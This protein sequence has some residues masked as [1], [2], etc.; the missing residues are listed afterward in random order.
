MNKLLLASLTLALSATAYATVSEV[1]HVSIFNHGQKVIQLETGAKANFVQLDE[2]TIP[3]NLTVKG[4]TNTDFSG[5]MTLFTSGTHQV[6]NI[7]SLS[8]SKAETAPSEVSFDVTVLG[9]HCYTFYYANKDNQ[10][11]KMG[12]ECGGNDVTLLTEIPEGFSSKEDNI[13]M[14]FFVKEGSMES[15]ALSFSTKV[16]DGKFVIDQPS[17]SVT[18]SVIAFKDSDAHLHFGTK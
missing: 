17:L 14:M 9:P 18:P 13:K 10:K 2:M 3:E 1:N 5:D 7:N 6:T 11:V 15:G 16:L 4:Y 8:I 12:E